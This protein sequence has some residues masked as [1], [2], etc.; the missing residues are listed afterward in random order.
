MAQI[1]LQGS[2]GFISMPP[3]GT[4]V[5]AYRYGHVTRRMAGDGWNKE[6]YGFGF[7]Y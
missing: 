7:K 2:K 3:L 1:E 6:V 5:K 4:V